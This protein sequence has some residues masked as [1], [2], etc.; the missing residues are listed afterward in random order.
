M[1]QFSCVLSRAHL[2]LGGRLK[3]VLLCTLLSFSISAC[4]TV[5][6]VVY[7]DEMTADEQLIREQSLDFKLTNILEGALVVGTVG[8]VVGAVAVSVATNGGDGLVAGC[9]ALGAAGA[10]IGGV[11]GYQNAL[12]AEDN[13]RKVARL[14]AKSKELEGKTD[15]MSGKLAA[16]RRVILADR[17]R[18]KHLS[19]AV[20][21][22]WYDIRLTRNEHEQIASN[23]EAIKRLI[24]SVR[25]YI[26][27]HD[28]E[29]EDLSLNDRRQ[30]SASV[31]DLTRE[32]EF[33]ERSMLKMSAELK[34]AGIS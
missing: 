12:F 20:E 1:R 28:D 34:L 27:E 26:E 10:A 5:E 7:G 3:A 25:D 23:N 17:R 29:A 11:D 21:K 31:E 8:C 13:A 33:L 30:L 18:M 19:D 9:I 22:K 4:S 15:E 16:A 24:A 32:V 2:S 14:Q 6:L